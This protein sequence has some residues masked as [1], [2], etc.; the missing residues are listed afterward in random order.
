MENRRIYSLNLACWLISKG[1][2]CE[3]FNDEEQEGKYYFIFDRDLGKEINEYKMD[4]E[5]HKFL[6]TYRGMRKEIRERRNV[7]EE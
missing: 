7:V 5:L 4:G 2:N 3:M 6:E 1:F